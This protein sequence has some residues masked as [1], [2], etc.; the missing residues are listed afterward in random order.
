MNKGPIEGVWGTRG[1]CRI[2]S[3]P[4]EAG[5]SSD[6]APLSV[7]RKHSICSGFR[8]KGSRLKREGRSEAIPESGSADE[9]AA[10]VPS[11]TT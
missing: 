7:A 4:A 10:R 11:D 9:T 6:N 1:E 3:F 5:K 8:A 2:L